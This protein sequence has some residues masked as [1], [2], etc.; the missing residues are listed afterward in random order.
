M[1]QS[2]KS[3]RNVSIFALSVLVLSVLALTLASPASAAANAAEIITGNPDAV[4]P[5]GQVIDD[6]LFITGQNVRI[7][8]TVNGDVFAAGSQVEVTGTIEGNL[9]VGAQLFTNNGTVNGGVYSFSYVAVTG[10]TAY[11]ADNMFGFA[12]AVQTEAGSFIG[13]SAYAFAYQAD[14]SGQIGRDLNV[15]G[16]AL[17][18]DGSIGRNLRAEIS[19]PRGDRNVDYGPWMVWMPANVTI[20]QPGYDV[21]AG[22]VTGE[23]DIQV[24]EY[25]APTAPNMPVS[26]PT[27]WGLAVAAWVVN[28]IGEFIALFLLGIL[29]YLVWPKQ[30]TR[31]EDQITT[32]PW[33]SLGL[34]FLA[35]VLFPFAFILAVVIIIL[36]AV[37]LG[38]I[39]L[40]H[41]AGPVLA[42][43]FLLLGLATTVFFIAG[44]LAAKAIIGHLVGG[45]I[46]RSS[47]EDKGWGMV[48]ILLVGLLL[49]EIVALVPI[50]GWLVALVVIFLGLGA[51][52]GALWIKDAKPKA[53]KARR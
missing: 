20:M 25:Q 13:R 44:L 24:V 46:L 15:Y 11:V 53:R 31:V 2:N 34:G 16:S 6:D 12:F 4:V 3:R 49:Y 45:F 33:R 52:A 35:A 17:H 10:P 43:G 9:F 1:L 48:L 21:A 28:R 32:H 42:L 50:L 8:G 39:S 7:E 38:V 18:F 51:M 41:L 36:L 30:M 14:V 19:E 5:A 29:L 40:G 47:V 27:L 22:T 37:L 23:T 26:A